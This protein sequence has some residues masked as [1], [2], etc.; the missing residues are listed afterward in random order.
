M[1]IGLIPCYNT[2]IRIRILH[3]VEL[4][5]EINRQNPAETAGKIES[6]PITDE[7]IAEAN[8]LFKSGKNGA[9]LVELKAKIEEEIKRKKPEISYEDIYGLKGTG[10]ESSKQCEVAK[11]HFETI[12]EMGGKPGAI[13]DFAK[14]LYKL[15]NW[16]IDPKGIDKSFDSIFENK[17]A[18]FGKLIEDTNRA[19]RGNYSKINEEWDS[20]FKKRGRG[21][22]I[23][24]KELGSFEKAIKKERL[25]LQANLPDFRIEAAIY[26]P[27]FA[28]DWRKDIIAP[29]NNKKIRDLGTRIK[30]RREKIQKF[31]SIGK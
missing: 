31:E 12:I 7:E 26:L 10:E 5:Q 25:G 21:E 18:K 15:E 24:K 22:Q 14:R 28:D 27:K 13:K 2:S 9:R 20:F 3:M 29:R 16:D 19:E 6:K 1:A 23:S 8:D 4:E 17:K 30:S 11:K